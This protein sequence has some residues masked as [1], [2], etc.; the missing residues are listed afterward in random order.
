MRSSTDNVTACVRTRHDRI[1]KK[2]AEEK[3][4]AQPIM[5]LKRQA[6]LEAE[7]EAEERRKR[8]ESPPTAQRRDVKAIEEHMRE[9][10]PSLTLAGTCLPFQF[11]L[12][13]MQRMLYGTLTSVE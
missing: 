1:I 10:N 3:S 11:P 12:D 2:D 9:E 8:G 6:V 4:R 7:H 13:P 5:R